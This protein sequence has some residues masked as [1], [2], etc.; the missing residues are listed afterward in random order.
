[1]MIWD[2]FAASGP[3]EHAIICG[4]MHSELYQHIRKNNV[5]TSVH[6]LNLK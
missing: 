1:M 2:C 4:T 5:R 6:V 3:G